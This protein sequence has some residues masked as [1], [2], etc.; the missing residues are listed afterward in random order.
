M[1]ID[2]STTY[3]GLELSG[4]I[5][6]S[7]SPLTGKLPSLKALEDAG[8]AAV[9]LP[10]LFEEEVAA[11]EFAVADLMDVGEGF[12]EFS[13]GVLPEMDLS[14]IGTA[15][16]LRHVEQAKAA[17]SIPV[18]ASLNATAPG[19]W[20]RFARQMQD[21]GADA[22]ELNLYTVA[23]NPHETASEVEARH[24]DAIAAVA[25]AVTIPL[26]VKLSPFYTAVANFAGRALGAGASGLVMFNRFYAPDLDLDTFAVEPKLELSHSSDLRLP[27][28]WIGIIRSQQPT[29][30][31]ALT[32]GVH[33]VADVVKGLAV[34]S[35]VV[36][37]TS[38][39]LH[40]GP[41]LI[42]TLRTELEEWLAAR[43]YTSV[44]ELR[45]SASASN[46]GDAGA[47]ERSQ[48][49]KIIQSAR[50]RY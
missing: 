12:A 43:E 16:R 38:G 21:A 13:G 22:L 17:L 45:G 6:A 50:D 36:C 9:V 7:A 30:S 20:S 4:P 14:G 29:A 26:A 39:V 40:D 19:A 10:S 35:T 42:T 11:E 5:I 27:L 33:T 18:I 23:A 44:S 15:Q 37:T 34:G 8:A 24:L 28:R 32:S 31:L 47:F 25:S 46:A 2:L 3:L 48:Y 41:G 49:M 1:S